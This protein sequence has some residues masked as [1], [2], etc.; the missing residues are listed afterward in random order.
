[1]IYRYK[2][3]VQTFFKALVGGGTSFMIA[4]LSLNCKEQILVFVILSTMTYQK[5]ENCK[6]IVYFISEHGPNWSL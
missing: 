4:A 1:M 3:L 5:K 2:D 6:F